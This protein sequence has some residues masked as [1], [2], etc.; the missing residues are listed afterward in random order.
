ME[1][2][3]QPA[4]AKA[5]VSLNADWFRLLQTADPSAL[6]TQIARL[7]KIGD[8]DLLDAFLAEHPEMAG[9][10]TVVP[11]PVALADALRAAD[12]G[13]YDRLANLFVVYAAPEDAT[14]LAEAVTADHA[15]IARL[16]H[17][18]VFGAEAALLFPRCGG[19]AAEYDGWLK[20]EFDRLL[21][22][23][24]D[25]ALVDFQR[26]ILIKGRSL[27]GRMQE[28]AGF[29]KDFPDLWR[30]L[31][32][33]ADKEHLPPEIVLTILDEPGVWK[34]LA[35]PD[36]G[37]LL[38]K[39][40][41]LPVSLLYGES[42]YPEAL[43]D[44][45]VQAMLQGDN[46]AVRAMFQFRTE[47]LFQR[48]LQRPLPAAIR[49]TAFHRLLAAPSDASPLLRKWDGFSDQALAEELGPQE[50]EG[51]QSWIPLYYDFVVARKFLQ[52]RDPNAAEWIIAVADP[53]LTLASFFIPGAELPGKVVATTLEKGGEEAVEREG[54]ELL[55]KE[56][57]EMAEKELAEGM[58]RQV[59]EQFAR[60]ELE[61]EAERWGASGLFGRTQ[62]RFLA[63][64]RALDR[65][66]TVDIDRPARFPVR[67]Q[68]GRP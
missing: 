27:R 22:S 60:K 65:A 61:G 50:P 49:R 44:R 57:V 64:G 6:R 5:V 43:H 55:E 62:E 14:A 10:L 32:L 15:V 2:G 46:Q 18:R 47:P 54:L 52:G 24:D 33:V 30:K 58:G 13:D 4:T 12:N 11:H 23:H 66:T 35:R 31:R 53:A 63:L 21:W 1:A 29:R 39:W 19:G 48:L 41:P 37:E 51:L 8:H 36:G 59:A 25:K 38:E 42:A 45:V 68:R 16:L 34:L 9:V 40:G 67:V 20:G 17:R 56:G 28:D 26:I 7:K 3:W